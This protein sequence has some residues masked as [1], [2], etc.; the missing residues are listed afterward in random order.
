MMDDEDCTGFA[1]E[2]GTGDHGAA[3][4]DLE[5]HEAAECESVDHE[6]ESE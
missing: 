3:E 4:R 5:D 1:V 6:A 2:D